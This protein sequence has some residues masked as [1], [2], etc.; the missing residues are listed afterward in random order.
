MLFK[1]SLFVLQLI[2]AKVK[3]MEIEMEV[4]VGHVICHMMSHIID[5]I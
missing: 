4:L 3:S 5:S 2:A 1:F